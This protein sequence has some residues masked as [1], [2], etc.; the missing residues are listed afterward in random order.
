MDFDAISLAGVWY[1]Q[2]PTRGEPAY[3]PEPPADARW[4]RHVDP[5]PFG[6]L[7]EREIAQILQV[8]PD[9]VQR[10]WKAARAWLYGQL[11]AQY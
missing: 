10:D 4:Q 5:E 7:D 2:I 1:R 8:S 11:T 9:T 3:R 6:G